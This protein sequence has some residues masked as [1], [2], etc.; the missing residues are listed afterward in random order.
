[1][2][3]G[4][5]ARG[6]LLVD[7]VGFEPSGEAFVG[8]VFLYGFAEFPSLELPLLFKMVELLQ[9]HS[10]LLIDPQ[11]LLPL[12]SMPAPLDLP[13]LR[14]L[15]SSL[16]NL[17]QPPL[18]ILVLDVPRKQHHFYFLVPAL[19]AIQFGSD[20]VLVDLV[21]GLTMAELHVF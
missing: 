15:H 8:L 10:V 12:L 21:G 1:M 16:R 2:S 7:G 14:Q 17:I 5:S 13:D 4:G 20:V 6:L 18:A 19:V 9:E 11:L 3:M